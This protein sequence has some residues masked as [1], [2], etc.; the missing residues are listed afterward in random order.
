MASKNSKPA[1]I[2]AELDE[3]LRKLMRDNNM[4][5]RQASK[6]AAKMLKGTKR[7]LEIKF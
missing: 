6:E 7:K 5:M 2:D 1:R 4:S 3:M